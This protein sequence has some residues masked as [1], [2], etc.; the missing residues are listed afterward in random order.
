MKK[1][2]RCVCGYIPYAGRRHTHDGKEFSKEFSEPVFSKKRKGHTQP[3]RQQHWKH[4]V[5]AWRGVCLTLFPPVV[6]KTSSKI[7]HRL[8]GGSVI[9]A[10]R[11]VYRT[12][13]T[14]DVSDEANSWYHS[15][16]NEGGGEY[17]FVACLSHLTL[18]HASLSRRSTVPTPGGAEQALFTCRA[19]QGEKGNRSG[20]ADM[21]TRPVVLA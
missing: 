11:T 3:K 14:F 17:W 1:D 21:L 6:H 8:A 5:K 20:R 4:L 9:F 7:T 15:A 13:H 16:R 10:C 19:M 12:W 2:A 18:D